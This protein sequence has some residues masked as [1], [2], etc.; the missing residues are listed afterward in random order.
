MGERKLLQ[1]IA[2]YAETVQECDARM[3]YSSNAALAQNKYSIIVT[4]IKKKSQK[5]PALQP[6]L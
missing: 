5:N 2:Q 3:N 4:A 1:K 6:G